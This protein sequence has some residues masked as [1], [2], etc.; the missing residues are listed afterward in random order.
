MVNRCNV[1]L[2]DVATDAN[3]PVLRRVPG[4]TNLNLTPG[5]VSTNG[6]LPTKTSGK[7][8]YRVAANVDMNVKF[9][10]TASPVADGTDRF[11]PAGL[12]EYVPADEWLYFACITV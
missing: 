12:V 10:T 2:Y 4:S 6:T 5:A 1:C 3:V 7:Q 8:F 9:S 11:W